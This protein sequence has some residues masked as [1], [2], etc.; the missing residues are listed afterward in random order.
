[1]VPDPMD[2]LLAI[3]T[4]RTFLIFDGFNRGKDRVFD[5]LVSLGNKDSC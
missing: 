1:V 3:R 2:F 4:G 5:R